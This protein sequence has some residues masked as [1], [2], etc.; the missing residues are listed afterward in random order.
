M[1]EVNVHVIH[2]LQ[3]AAHFLS[4]AERT[5]ADP[6]MC[7]RKLHTQIKRA[8]ADARTFVETAHLKHDDAEELAVPDAKKTAI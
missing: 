5:A 3:Q 1:K 2:A 4:E 6:A 8:A 7:S